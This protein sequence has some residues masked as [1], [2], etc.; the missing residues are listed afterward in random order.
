MSKIKTIITTTIK[1]LDEEVE[2]KRE[3]KKKT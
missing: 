3:K 1:A 2:E